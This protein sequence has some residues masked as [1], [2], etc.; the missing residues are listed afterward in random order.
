MI[1]L[2]L[3]YFIMSFKS[4]RDWEQFEYKIQVELV[5]IFKFVLDYEDGLNFNEDLENFL[6]KV[7]VFF[8]CFSIFFEEFFLFSYQVKREICFLELQKVVFFFSGNN[9]FL[10]FLVFFMGDILQILQFQM[11]WLKKQFVDERSNRDEL[12]LELVE[13]CKFF[14]EK[15]VQIVM[16]QQCIDCL[17]LLNEKQVVSLLE[18]KEFEELCDKNESFIM[19]LYEILKQCQDLKIEKSQMDCKINQF[20]EENGDF[21]FKLWEFVSY[22]QQLQDVF[23]ELMEEYSKVIQEW[24]EKQ[25]QLEKEFSVVLQDKKCFEEKNEIFQGKFL[26]LEEYLFQLQDNLFQEKGEVLGDVLQ[27]EILK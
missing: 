15:D 21:F 25:V 10:G 27:L 20:L 18:F 9:F 1:M 14:I 13:N 8:I 19:W 16:M 5:V 23:N 26:Q 4:F 3:Y 6:Q 7:F 17:V 24:L 12:E 11:R 2:F 22:L